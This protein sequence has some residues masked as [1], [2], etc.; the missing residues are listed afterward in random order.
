MIVKDKDVLFNNNG[1]IK[2]IHLIISKND[3]VLNTI[4]SY[5][6]LI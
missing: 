2:L 5:S 1:N 3:L 6:I 4:V